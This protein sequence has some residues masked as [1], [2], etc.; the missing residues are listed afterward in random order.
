LG[1]TGLPILS[2]NPIDKKTIPLLLSSPCQRLLQISAG[3]IPVFRSFI[4][5]L[6]NNPAFF[7]IPRVLEKGPE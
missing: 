2:I 5:V 4:G 7:E 1:T 3:E 6:K